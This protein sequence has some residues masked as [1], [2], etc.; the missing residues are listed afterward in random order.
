[1]RP[2]VRL[3]GARDVHDGGIRLSGGRGSLLQG[4]KA[5]ALFLLWLAG[6]LADL[7]EYFLRVGPAHP[8]GKA[9]GILALQRGV[10]NL[11]HHRHRTAQGLEAA[12][13][14]VNAEVRDDRA[15]DELKHGDAVRHEVAHGSVAAL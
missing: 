12:F 10:A 11:R 1:M 6:L 14:R 13:G 5:R 4:G 3:A 2:Q 15:D 8:A 7:L 9:A